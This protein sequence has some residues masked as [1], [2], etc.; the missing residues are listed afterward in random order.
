MT[1]K[2]PSPSP[3]GPKP[4]PAA[5]PHRPPI[6]A[7]TSQV[8]VSLAIVAAMGLLGVGLIVAGL[9]HSDKWDAIA[10]PIGTIVGALAVALKTPSGVTA[11]LAESKK[12]TPP[13]AAGQ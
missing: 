13:P 8:V 4:A 9:I 3:A 12:P 6:T 10:L 7:Q 1:D 2:T 5:R 11:A